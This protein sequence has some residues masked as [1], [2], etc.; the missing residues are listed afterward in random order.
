MTSQGRSTAA[1][2]RPP[3]LRP[4]TLQ[5]RAAVQGAARRARGLPRRRGARQGQR[6]RQRAVAARSR[7]DTPRSTDMMGLPRSQML[8]PLC[9]RAHSR[10]LLPHAG[11]QTNLQACYSNRKPE[12]FA[13]VAALPYAAREGRVAHWTVDELDTL[14]GATQCCEQPRH[15][16][17]CALSSLLPSAGSMTW[18]CFGAPQ[19]EHRRIHRPGDVEDVL[20]R[21]PAEQQE[22]RSSEHSPASFS[23]EAPPLCKLHGCRD[24]QGGAG[25]RTCCGPCPRTRSRR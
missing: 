7:Y 25:A 2:A 12:H 14:Q 23:R 1:C 21:G 22:P 18:G 4:G 15:A 10:T 20:A 3:A 19:E 11:W 17:H 24:P 16:Q 6:E 9:M 8:G 13:D 5:K